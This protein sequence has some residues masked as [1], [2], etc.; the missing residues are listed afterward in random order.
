[1]RRSATCWEC[2]AT[3]EQPVTVTI[4]TPTRIVGTLRLCPGCYGA[5][6]LPLTHQPSDP[7][8]SAPPLLRVEVRGTGTLVVD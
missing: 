6:F 1:M 2:E 3:T 4:G 8:E 7:A 5:C